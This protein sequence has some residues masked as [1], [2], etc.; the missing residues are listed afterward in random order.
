MASA[1]P[2]ILLV[3]MALGRS[4]EDAIALE[5]ELHKAFAN[6]RMNHI[7]QRRE[8]FF[9]TPVEVRDV[10]AEKVGGLLEFREE[11]EALEYFQSRSF[12]PGGD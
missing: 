2:R 8:F 4:D 5:N 3:V 7:N 11:P 10:L 12:W 9:A 6:R 1:Q